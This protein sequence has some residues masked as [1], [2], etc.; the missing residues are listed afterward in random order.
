MGRFPVRPDKDIELVGDLVK[1]QFESPR[2]LW[3]IK[4]TN[5]RLTERVAAFGAGISRLLPQESSV[6]LLLNDSLEFLIADLALA[7]YSIVS[8]TLNTRKLLSRVLEAHPPSA[9]IVG[10][11][12]LPHLLELIHDAKEY[13]RRIIVVGQTDIDVRP[14]A[15][16]EAQIL[17]WAQVE[18]DGA[19]VVNAAT[20]P[21]VRPNDPFTLTF[22]ETSSGDLQ[23]VRFTHSHFTSGVTAIRA[24]FPPSIAL[25]TLD[26]IVSGHSLSTPFGRA[27]AYTALYEGACFATCDSTRTY[28]NP[29]IES[30][31]SPRN[32]N[33]IL[34]TSK[35]PI[36]SPTVLVLHPDHVQDLSTAILSR[37]KKSSIIYPVVW[38]HKLAALAEGFVS[39][40][41]LWDRLVFDGA[42]EHILGR[43]AG[44]LKAVVVGGGP[45][46]NDAL[47][48]ARISLSVPIVNVLIHPST[49]GPL[50]ATHAFD[51]QSLPSIEDE[52]A[53]V[54]A[55][56]VNVE[57]KLTGADDAAIERGS[58]P[59]GEL[60]V[61]GP[62]VGTLLSGAANNTETED[63]SWVETG[64]IARVMTNGA[65]KVIGKPCD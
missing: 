48:P 33:D 8:V 55:P 36:P 7:R 3:S 14:K 28:Y 35:L 43:M 32:V 56:S 63:Q 29:D 50:C 17:N 64:E 6:L 15:A 34:S 27:V 42:R 20:P 65:F 31:A 13:D 57:V 59:N 26:T 62:P 37:A 21:S 18:A 4:I 45:L 52:P 10:A 60:L 5:A 9:I 1:P 22:S 47:T 44:T 12:F 11:D 39:K 46:P 30:S 58:D 2:T 49:S 53:H 41:S 38:R 23:G 25:S 54:G 51:L 19:Q 61:R 24:L 40:E 16:R